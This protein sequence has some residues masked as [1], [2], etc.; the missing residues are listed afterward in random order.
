MREKHCRGCQCS[1]IDDLT[2]H[3][4]PCTEYHGIVSTAGTPGTIQ[5]ASCLSSHVPRYLTIEHCVLESR[6]IHPHLSPPSP[7][8]PTKLWAWSSSA[9]GLTAPGSGNIEYVYVLSRHPVR[10]G[11]EL[12]ATAGGQWN[13]VRSRTSV[14]DPSIIL[15]F[16][17]SFP[18]TLTHTPYTIS[19]WLQTANGGGC[20]TKRRARAERKKRAAAPDA[21]IPRQEDT[22][23]G[24]IGTYR[25]AARAHSATNL[26]DQP[27]AG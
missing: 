24:A 1:L 7:Q 16:D 4:I 3:C 20:C 5:P 8:A 18:R 10:L 9:R 13:H 12:R 21:G 2:P 14:H 26:A 27:L 11:R 15:G 23:L 19:R 25:A 22:Y 6:P 17:G